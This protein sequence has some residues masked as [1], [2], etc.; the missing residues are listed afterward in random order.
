M[1]RSEQI[2]WAA[3]TSST[4][5][6]PT[7]QRPPSVML[8]NRSSFS[9]NTPSKEP[10]LSRWLSPTVV[11]T[12]I[13]GRAIAESVE[14]SPGSFEPISTT[15][16]STSVGIES[17]VS[18]TPMRLLR[19][20]G[21]ACT[22]RVIPSAARVRSFVVVFPTDPVIATTGAFRSLRRKLASD[23]SATRVSST[24]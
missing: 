11:T 5:S 10:S 17:S 16:T 18:G 20:S 24:G 3:S 22:A 9:S 19:L 15:I 6:S 1:R 4:G 13:S 8:R 23:P 14:I 12:A 2:A 21:V 7:T